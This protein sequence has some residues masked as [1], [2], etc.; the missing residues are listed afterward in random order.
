MELT[1]EQRAMLN[2]DLGRG[3]AMAMGVQVGIGKCF[4]APRMV[5]VQKVH[6]S[7]SAQEADVWFSGRLLEAGASCAVAPTVNPGY[8]LDYFRKHLTPEAIA[9]MEET[10]R[11]YQSL[12]AR[13]TYSCTPYLGDNVPEYGEAAAFS[14]TNATIFVNAVLGARTNRE[15][16]ASALCAAVTGCVPEYG[17]LLDENRKGDIVVHVEADMKSAYE[18]HL[19]GMMGDKIGEGIPVFTGLPKVITPEALRNLGA[20]LNTSGAYGMYH[21]VGFTPE[22]PDLETALGHKKPRY[23]VTITDRDLKEFEETFSDKIPNGKIDFAMFGCPHFT[24]EEAMYI[25]KHIE[26]KKLAVPMYILVSSHA[27]QMAGRMGVTDI[28]AA[29]GAEIIPD[30]C[31]DQPC[32][33]YLK[34]KVGITESP[35][36][37]Y[38]PRRR[39]INFIIRDLDT[40]IQAA[41]TGE[42]N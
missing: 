26:G 32:W 23:E 16:A 28:L 41:L 9:N 25:A 42:V 18:Y 34:G 5:P 4:D 2:G 37:A 35:K 6:V 20:Q 11:I 24:L 14:E 13:L 1:A 8:S 7:L 27:S 30:T 33:H 3:K 39:G 31:P 19:L 21:I 36:C 38:Y 10:H 40:C 15:S 12:G 22:A 29:A 17:L